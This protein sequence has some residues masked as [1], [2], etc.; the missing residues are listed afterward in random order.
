MLNLARVAVQTRGKIPEMLSELGISLRVLSQRLSLLRRLGL[1]RTVTLFDP[2][3]LGLSAGA[4]VM[5]RM[6]ALD[7][8]ALTAF[9]AYLVASDCVATACQVTGDYD[10]RLTTFHADWREAH[11]WARALGHRHDVDVAVVMMSQRV[12]GHELSGLVLR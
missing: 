2:A 5:V 1:A 9:E 7:A 11:Q 12:F 4:T 8:R 3:G 10:Y 6:A